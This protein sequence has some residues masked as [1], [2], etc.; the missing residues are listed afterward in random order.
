MILITP[1][2]ERT[3]T[4]AAAVMHGLAAPSQE[5]W[6]LPPGRSPSSTA[7]SPRSTS[8]TRTRSGCR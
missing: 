3:I 5:A 2:E 8:S 7:A 1:T 4:T 6:K